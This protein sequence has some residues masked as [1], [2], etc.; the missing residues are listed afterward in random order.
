MNT[1]EHLTNEVQ[2]L[3][4][5]L[6]QPDLNPTTEVAMRERHA[7]ASARLADLESRADYA[8]VSTEDLQ[9]LLEDA[10]L[11]RE[12]LYPQ[13]QTALQ[14]RANRPALARKLERDYNDLA[15]SQAGL[16]SELDTRQFQ[17]ANVVLPATVPRSSL[18]ARSARATW[19]RSPG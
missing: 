7:L 17:E 8:E 11:R 5:A 2:Q 10:E 14:D 9:G 19:M 3:E 18:N 12:E 15:Q 4:Q 1:I 6:A 16:R 13:L